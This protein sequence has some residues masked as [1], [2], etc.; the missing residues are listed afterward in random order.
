MRFRNFCIPAIDTVDGPLDLMS[1]RNSVLL[2]APLQSC[3][4]ASKR[5]AHQAQA[6]HF[7]EIHRGK[8][9]A[10]AAIR[11]T[12]SELLPTRRL[13]RKQRSSPR[14]SAPEGGPSPTNPT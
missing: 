4:G 6:S 13:L 10:V 9:P 11:R 12:G 3:D 8:V 2:L 5:K 1:G 7:Y 14:R